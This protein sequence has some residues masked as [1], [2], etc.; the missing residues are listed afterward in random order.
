MTLRFAVALVALVAL[1][2][3][4]A[5]AVRT[6]SLEEAVQVAGVGLAFD[7]PSEG[8]FTLRLQVKNPTGTAA[9]VERLRFHLD[10]DGRP[11]AS[12]VR[13]L[14]VP[15]EARQQAEL[16]VRFPLVL[17]RGLDAHVRQATNVRARVEGTAVLDFN[18]LERTAPYRYTMDLRVG[19][20]PAGSGP[21]S[22]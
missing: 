2:G 4:R 7:A 13:E 15:V 8:V 12:G 16:A 6:A 3:C 17:P 9:V 1:T 20:T 19:G 22:R 10:V 21:T 5:L 11:L 14:S 18:G